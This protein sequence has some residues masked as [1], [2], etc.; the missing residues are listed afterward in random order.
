M[1]LVAHVEGASDTRMQDAQRL[2][3]GAWLEYRDQYEGARAE[4]LKRQAELD[5]TRA[6]IAKLVAMA[7]LAR[8]QAD[9]YRALVND[10]YVAR[11]DYLDK[12]QQALDKEHELAVQRSHANELAAGI[13]EQHAQVD[14]T[15]SKF[16][17]M[18][19]DELEKA[20]QQITQSRNDETKAQTRQALLS[21]TAPV[22]GTV[23]QLA[24]HTLGG[25]VTT[26]IRKLSALT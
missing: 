21:L 20:T 11:N 16:R 3:E 15:A 7:P 8:Q 1:P 24:V 13:A 25:V 17:R 2:A 5:S 22:P 6:Q 23:Q 10:R 18:Q 26:A 4:L 19:L 12:E 9:A 14:A